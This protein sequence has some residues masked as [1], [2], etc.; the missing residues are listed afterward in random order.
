[1]NDMN[2][3][4]YLATAA[5]F[6]LIGAG[7]AAPAPDTRIEDEGG[8]EAVTTSPVPAPESDV[9]KVMEGGNE[10]MMEGGHMNDSGMTDDSAKT[11]VTVSFDGKA[12][13]PSTVTVDAGT[14]VVFRN[15]SSSPFWPASDIHPTHTL[16]DGSSL[17][18][19][20][21]NGSSSFDSCGGISSGDSYSFTFDKVGSWKYHDHLHARNVG[22]VIVK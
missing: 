9:E 10:A 5:L 6:I 19:H 7:C 8:L 17:A 18:Q 11:A 12:F 15:D 4:K 1:M 22:T 16:Y 3:T 14:T 2:Y 20:C 13:S 21:K